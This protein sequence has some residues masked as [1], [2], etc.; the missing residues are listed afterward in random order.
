MYQWFPYGIAHKSGS[1]AVRSIGW[2]AQR[3]AVSGNRPRKPR[4]DIV[5]EDVEGGWPDLQVRLPAG[6]A[7]HRIADAQFASQ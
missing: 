6:F 4:V 3:R 5:H 1:L 2:L 7:D